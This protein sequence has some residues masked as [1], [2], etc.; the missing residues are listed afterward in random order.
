VP[1]SSI[2]IDLAPSRKLA[3][4]ASLPGSASRRTRQCFGHHT[5]RLLRYCIGSAAALA[6]VYHALAPELD[7]ARTLKPVPAGLPPGNSRHESRSATG[8]SSGG[9]AGVSTNAALASASRAKRNS[10]PECSLVWQA[11]VRLQCHPRPLSGGSES[12]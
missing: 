6:S 3:S 9:R 10:R 8:L 2:T 1:G 4:S 11:A 5:R 12:A 7:E